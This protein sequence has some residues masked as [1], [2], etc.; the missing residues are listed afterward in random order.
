MTLALPVTILSDHGPR[1][2]VT[3]AGIPGAHMADRD[4]L[5]R[6]PDEEDG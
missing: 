4:A 2:L 1:V 5:V 3:V 6:V